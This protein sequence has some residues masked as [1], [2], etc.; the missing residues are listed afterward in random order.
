MLNRIRQA[1]TA[2]IAAVLVGAGIMAA[3]NAT[4]QQGN[5]VIFGDSVI[6]DA[7][8]IEYLSLIHI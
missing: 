8:S 4:A 2:F 3:P 6:A 7:H 1:V 5:M